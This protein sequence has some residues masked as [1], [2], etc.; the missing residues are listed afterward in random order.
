M[1]SFVQPLP[2]GNAVK[3]LLAPPPTAEKVRVLR[4][5]ADTFT[6]E[7]DGAAGIVYEGDDNYVLDVNTLV[8]GTVYYYR[9]YYFDGT[10]WSA[11][12][13]AS[14]TPA[15]TANRRGPDPLSLVRDR[16][17][18][19]LKAEVA[20]GRLKHEQQYIPCLTAPPT[21][22]GT[23]FPV[24]TVHLRNDASTGRALGEVLFDDVY[25]P[26]ALEWGSSEGWLSRIQIDVIGW[27]VGNADT[28]IAL[29]KAIQK[30]IIGNLSVFDQAGMVEID[31]SQSDIE[32]FETYN[33]PMYQTMGSFSCMAPAVVEAL[34]APIDDVTVVCALA[35]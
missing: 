21:F 24:V 19:G 31:F 27:V 23:A 5:L 28:R 32:D 15:A 33:A 14:A 13:T 18:A 26:V 6:G 29:R 11:G 9:P 3:L 34:D 1:I 2:I 8:N 22:D 10:A 17:E 7:T 35:A 20:A 25:D 12:L 30:V 4:K 16:L